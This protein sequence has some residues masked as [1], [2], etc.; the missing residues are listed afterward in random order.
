MRNRF[1]A[2]LIA[3]ILVV[4]CGGSAEQSGDA[5]VRVYVSLPL[6]GSTGADGRDAADGA[7]LALA[8][9][10]EGAGG[11][12]IEAVVLDDTGGPDP[13]WTPE[14]AAANAREATEDSTAIAYLGD[15][16]SGATRA[17]LPVTNEARLLQVSPASAAVDLVAPFPGTDEVPETQPSGQRSFGRVI[18]ADDVQAAAAARWAV[19]L[20]WRAAAVESDGTPFG[21]LLGGAFS[22]AAERIGLDLRRDAGLTYLA[23]TPPASGGEE[24]GSDAYLATEGPSPARV[25]SAA[26]D[27][28]QL[29]SAGRRFAAEF[30][31]EYG[32]PPG[33]YGAYGYEA[34]ALILDSIERASNPL[35]RAAVIDA[36]FET[37]ARDSVLGTYSIDE[38]GDTSLDRVTG[39]EL[40]AGRP[41]P[42]VELSAAG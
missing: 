4:G 38:L 14:R 11:V 10:G 41:E 33:R 18:P 2:S 29:P 22:I 15:F 24:I 20:G 42:A 35:D 5:V 12:A 19:D 36:F 6:R 7:R 23:G 30:E 40:G 27:P 31:G 28:S 21:R 25:T 16:E 13:G 26:L 37:T 34:M 39:Y 8:D 9:A 3:A 1:W 32:R 17:S